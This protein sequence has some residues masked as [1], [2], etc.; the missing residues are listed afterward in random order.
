MVPYTCIHLAIYKGKISFCLFKLFRGLLV[1]Q[2]T[3]W[4]NA[5][6]VIKLILS[7]STLMEWFCRLAGDFVVFIILFFKQSLHPTWDMS[8]QP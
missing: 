7:S 5:H 8:S 6:S 2:I 4:F 3:F 1:M